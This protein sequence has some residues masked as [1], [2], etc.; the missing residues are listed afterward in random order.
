MIYFLNVVIINS[1]RWSKTNSYTLL[2]YPLSSWLSSLHMSF[3]EI[4]HAHLGVCICLQFQLWE[5]GTGRL[6][7]SP[8]LTVSLKKTSKGLCV[9]NKINGMLFCFILRQGL[10][11]ALSGPGLAV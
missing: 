7:S 2:F 11:I 10:T 5:T 6:L 9:I 4:S 1:D 3:L 8:G